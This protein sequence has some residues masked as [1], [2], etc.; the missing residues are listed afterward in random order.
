MQNRLSLLSWLIGCLFLLVVSF[1]Y[2]RWEIKHTECTLGWDVSGY[3]LYLPAFL[4]YDDPAELK[5][6]DNIMKEYKP[7]PELMQAYKHENGNYIMKYSAGMSL[8]YLP[9]FLVGH[10]FAKWLDYPIDGFSKPYQ[11]AIYF[12]SLFIAMVGFWFSRKN[13]LHFFSDKI[14]AFTLLILLFGTN[15]LNYASFDSAMT[16]NYIFTLLALLIHFTIQFY[17][18]PNYKYGALIG[19]CI[20]LA[21]LARPSDIVIAIVPLFWGLYSKASIQERFSFLKLHFPKFALAILVTG[22]IGFIQ[23]IYWKIN[24]GTWLEYSYQEQGFSWRGQHFGDFT[25]SYRKGWLLYTP[26]MTFGVLGFYF[27]FKQHRKYFWALFIFAL[28]NFYIISAWDIWW[29]G[30]SIGQRPMVQSYAV[31]VFPIA[32]IVAFSL[33]RNWAK[34]LFTPILLFCFWLNLF[35]TWQAHS[36]PWEPRYMTK[37]YYWRIF[38]KTAIQPT[39]KFLL[40]T[41]HDFKGDRKNVQKI[42]QSDFETNYDSTRITDIYAHSGKHAY[43]VNPDRKY[44]SSIDIPSTPAIKKAKWL[45]AKAWFYGDDFDWEPWRMAQFTVKFS[46]GKEQ[47]QWNMIKPQRIMKA[48][49]WK[50]AWIDVKIPNEDFDKISIYLW[51]GNGYRLFLI[52]DLTVEVYDE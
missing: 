4:I 37:S 45:R 25:F 3:Y 35:Q 27:L 31:M 34:W 8:M 11:A 5:F 46:K 22:G 9:G 21:A 38:G 39:D 51:V 2:S 32:A 36:G 17:R 15:Y 6:M 1:F 42:Y 24:A 26:L 47:I 12:W 29:Y 20:G 16:H 19:M 48:D 13:L 10:S 50:E 49:E 33:K 7:T 30:G 44:S 14:T 23:L 28:V 43:Y 52:D 41:E 18:Q 40:D